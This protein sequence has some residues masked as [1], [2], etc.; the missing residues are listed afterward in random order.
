MVFSTKFICL[1]ALIALLGSALSVFAQDTDSENPEESLKEVVVTATRIEEETSRLPY[2]VDRIDSGELAKKGIFSADEMF[3]T[4]SDFTQ[5]RGGVPGSPMLYSMRGTNE[6]HTLFLIDGVPISNPFVGS[7]DIENLTLTGFD[8]VEIL[9]SD[10]CVLYGSE[11]I[12]GVVNFVSEPE[13]ASPTFSV[14]GR[15]GNMG[16]SDEG[17]RIY[18]AADDRAF[19][20][21]ARETDIYG[22]RENEEFHALHLAAYTRINPAP[23]LNIKTTLRFLDVRK[24]MS[25]DIIFDEE[26]GQL[27]LVRD[28]DRVIYSKTLLGGATAEH[29][30]VSWWTLGAFANFFQNRQIEENKA[31]DTDSFVPNTLDVDITGRRLMAGGRTTFHMADYNDLTMGFDYRQDESLP[32]LSA[33]YLEP[34]TLPVKREERINHAFYAFDLFD[35][36]GWFQLAAGARYTDN[37]DYDSILTRKVNAAF[38]IKPLGVKLFG[39]YGEGYRLPTTQEQLNPLFGN[40]DLEAE[41]SRNYET[42]IQARLF[43]NK[44]FAR[45]VYFHIDF[46]DLIEVDPNTGRLENI[47]ESFSKGI[48]SDLKIGPFLGFSV[49]GGHLYNI[50]E[51]KDTDET[52]PF[53]PENTYKYD[54]EYEYADRF[55]IGVGGLSVDEWEDPTPIINEDGELLDEALSAYSVIHAFAAADI[56]RGNSILKNARIFGRGDNL[57]DEDYEEQRGTPMPGV[58]FF[59][60]L[61]VDFQR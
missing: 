42:G 9:R 16:L 14:T 46:E 32:L 3:N 22:E 13:S 38:H 27:R 60:G 41:K 25:Q 33:S 30:A 15:A 48:E 61:Q 31:D 58:T 11:A 40:E 4:V 28:E 7:A 59:A 50:A 39:G 10:Q 51:N 1:Y 24:E 43:G 2:A 36:K 21:A 56:Y 49:S 47:G 17:G 53:R 34:Q 44:V 52:L 26:R 20:V 18:G 45:S 19:S 5:Y 6:G 57:L 37:R 35:Y 8:H 12:G 29:Q 23:G 55:L 54:L